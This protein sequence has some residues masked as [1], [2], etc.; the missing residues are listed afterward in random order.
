MTLLGVVRTFIDSILVHAHLPTLAL[1]VLLQPLLFHSTWKTQADPLIVQFDDFLSPEEVD[2]MKTIAEKTGYER[3]GVGGTPSNTVESMQRTSQHVFLTAYEEDP[4]IKALNKKI[5]NVL[6]TPTDEHFEHFQVVRYQGKREW[7]RQ[8]SDLITDGI[9]THGGFRIATFFIYL[10]DN[11]NGGGE[12]AFDNGVKVLP[13][14]GRAVLWF[15]ALDADTESEVVPDS[16][17]DHQAMP[18]N[19]VNEEKIGSNVWIHSKYKSPFPKR[20]LLY[21]TML[22]A[23][24]RMID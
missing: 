12:T 9:G 15:N 8:H 17:V 2:Y 5:Q 13:K 7:Y 22:S 10:S 24:R 21:L 1:Y 18:L 23:T 14:R 11:Q 16:R 4:T 19:D 20:S 6:M 3:S